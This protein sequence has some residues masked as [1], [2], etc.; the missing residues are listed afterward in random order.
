MP[1]DNSDAEFAA[2]ADAADY[3]CP[4]CGE[5]IVVPL[6]ISAGR[7]QEYV[8]D[9]PVC[10]CPNHLTVTWGRDGTVTVTCQAE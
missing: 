4:S 1:R 2:P 7:D 5:V 6:D 3:V 10:C 9:C 8:E